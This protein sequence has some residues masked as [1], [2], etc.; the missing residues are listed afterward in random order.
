MEYTDDQIVQEVRTLIADTLR[1]SP[2]DVRM[3]A[4]LGEELGAESLD[5]IE[6]E[7][8]L[9]DY[10]LINFQLGGIFETLSEV[11]G[12]DT[13]VQD[14]RLTELG[15][16]ILRQR[17]PEVCPDKI[18]AGAS[19]MIEAW[20]TPSTW[21]RAVKEV[22]AAR[23]TTCPNCGSDRVK[24]VKPSVLACDACRSELNCPTQA[25]VVTAWAMN[26]AQRLDLSGR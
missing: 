5:L 23:P 18:V 3:D 20:Y 24:P 1:I 7:F 22:L 12:V 4:V 16:S 11:F 21:V 15:A 26:M 9:E 17:M 2:E 6:L 8:R 10:F 25:E 13:L 14:G 19:P